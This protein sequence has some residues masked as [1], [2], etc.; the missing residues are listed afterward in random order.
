[1]KKNNHLKHSNYIHTQ[2]VIIK[3]T[4]ESLI[5]MSNPK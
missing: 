1:M 5:N 2:E 3:H 4:D